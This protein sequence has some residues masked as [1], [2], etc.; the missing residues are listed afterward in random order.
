MKQTIEC[1]TLD[2]LFEWLFIRGI[3]CALYAF[4]LFAAPAAAYDVKIATLTI[5][6]P[7]LVD[8]EVFKIRVW[9]DV[10]GDNMWGDACL[11]GIQI[12]YTVD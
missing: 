11:L 9:R 12:K 1:I 3:R 10:S 8:D 6:T 4:G 7:E 2:C 5:A